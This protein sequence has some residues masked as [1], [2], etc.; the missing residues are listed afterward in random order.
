MTRFTPD[1]IWHGG[2]FEL[3]IEVGDRS[4]A[5]INAALTL[6]WQYPLLVGCYPRRDIE[7]ETQTQ[8]VPALVTD[9]EWPHSY[10]IAAIAKDKRIAC[11]SCVVRETDG[12]D[13]LDFYFPMGSLGT[14]YKV[15]GYPFINSEEQPSWLPEVELWLAKLGLWLSSQMEFRMA[16]IGFEA[17]GTTD[18]A[19]I[20]RE[21]GV[22]PTRYYGYLLPEHDQFNY[23]PSNK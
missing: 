8:S 11:G 2:F 16:L 3:S 21:G 14:A 15:G 19:T 1:E 5:R 6:L 7:P 18:A 20:S 23:Y 4:T 9:D 12:P 13:W 10:G 22:P 17:S